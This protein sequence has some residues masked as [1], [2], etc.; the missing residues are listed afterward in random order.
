MKNDH[1]FLSASEPRFLI[2]NDAYGNELFIPIARIKYIQTCFENNRH[3]II[4]RMIDQEEDDDHFYQES[5]ELEESAVD[6][7]TDIK[8]IIGA[9]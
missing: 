8:E 9:E 3:L 2:T 7:L 6:R 1:G 4:I 5:F